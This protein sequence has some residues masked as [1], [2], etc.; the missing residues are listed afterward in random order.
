MALAVGERRRGRRFRNLLEEGK[1]KLF[2]AIG[3][4]ALWR[5]SGAEVS[6][7]EQLTLVSLLWSLGSRACPRS[8]FTRCAWCDAR[9]SSSP[10]FAESRRLMNA[11]RGRSSEVSWSRL[12]N[13]K[14]RE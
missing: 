7:V 9:D 3:K 1:R 14:G 13:K 5:S 6:V 11:C 12:P 10:V 8:V 2:Q 4:V